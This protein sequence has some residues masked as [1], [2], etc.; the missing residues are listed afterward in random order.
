MNWRFSGPESVRS[1]DDGSKH[2]QLLSLTTEIVAA[3]ASN[4]AP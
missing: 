1:V 4:K 2:Q 3:F